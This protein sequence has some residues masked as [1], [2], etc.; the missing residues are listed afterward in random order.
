M[1]ANGCSLYTSPSTSSP[2]I[3]P[4]PASSIPFPIK[5]LEKFSADVVVTNTV[6]GETKERVY[7]VAKDGKRRFETYGK[8]SKVEFSLLRD[9]A[10]D[11]FR[12]NPANKEF[13]RLERKSVSHATDSLTKSLT[14]RWLNEKRHAEFVDL[15]VDNGLRKYQVKV[16]D[17][18]N[19]EIL[20]FVD[21]K[22]KYPVKQQYFSVNGDKRELVYSIELRNISTTPDPK[23]FELPK[24]Y[25]ERKGGETSIRGTENMNKNTP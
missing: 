2:D 8:D 1:F 4:E 5:D 3:D 25:K 14:S 9:S 13:E 16:E 17:S 22:L 19:T 21:E 20:V 15:G 12:L 7:F 18:R 24:Q 11:N 6:G 10:D 23:L